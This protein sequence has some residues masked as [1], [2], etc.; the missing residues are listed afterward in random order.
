MK[1]MNKMK[2]IKIIG[3]GGAGAKT[4]SYIKNKCIPGAVCIAMDSAEEALSAINADVKV[5]CNENI[6][7][8]E[9]AKAV[10]IA[11]D[12]AIFII[13]GLGGSCGGHL[14]EIA[15]KQIP[16]IICCYCIMPYQFE[17]D[18]RGENAVITHYRLTSHGVNVVKIDNDEVLSKTLNEPSGMTVGQ[19]HESISDYIYKD[20]LKRT[21]DLAD[22]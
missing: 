11:A 19:M 5:V 21:E 15:A 16:G 12:N 7:N 14:A 2:N 17:G 1:G 9:F 13:A 8:T 3:C 22:I 18:A 20:I 10:G 4:I 6:D